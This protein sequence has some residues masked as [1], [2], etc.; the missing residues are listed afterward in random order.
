MKLIATGDGLIGKGVGSVLTSLYQM[1][2]EVENEILMTVYSF[3]DATP[4][5]LLDKIE[6]RLKE[7]IRVIF[8]VNKLN[9][10]PAPVQALLKRWDESHTTFDHHDFHNERGEDLHAKVLVADRKR[11]IIGSS[12]LSW[13]GLVKNYELGIL[14]EEA[15]IAEQIYKSVVNLIPSLYRSD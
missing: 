7:G 8:V 5:S 4:D 11:A 2:D 12:N 15:E 10:Q 9:S 3:S 14:I 1:I 13:N 6:E